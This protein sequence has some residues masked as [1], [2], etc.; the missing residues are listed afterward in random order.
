MTQIVKRNTEFTLFSNSRIYFLATFAVFFFIFI[1][2][3]LKKGDIFIVFFVYSEM[4]CINP[5]L[6]LNDMPEEMNRL[7][8]AATN[9]S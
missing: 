5:L 7:C 4:S 2:N 9:I 1:S 3:R 6:K 8:S